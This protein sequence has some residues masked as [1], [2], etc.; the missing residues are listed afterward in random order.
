MAGGASLELRGL[1]AGGASLGVVY[2]EGTICMYT[3]ADT[4]ALGVKERTEACLPLL[5]LTAL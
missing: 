2:A 5:L 1:M 3:L 4:C